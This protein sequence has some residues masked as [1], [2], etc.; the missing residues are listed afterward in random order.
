MLETMKGREQLEAMMLDQVE[1]LR[2]MR[3]QIEVQSREI[4]TV[5]ED[6]R[7]RLTR[8]EMENKLTVI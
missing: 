4:H 6:L 8:L 2:N 5:S 7:N 3:S 1:A